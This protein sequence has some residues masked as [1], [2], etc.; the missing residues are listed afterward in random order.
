MLYIRADMNDIIATGHVMRCLAI[1]EA[2]K[3]Q[4]EDATFL[5]ADE[6]AVN[7]IKERG[8]QSIV[9]HT[10]WNDMEAELP[11]IETVIRE[12]NIKKL[13]IDSYQ[14]TPKY[15]E[16]LTAIVK[17]IYIDDLNAFVY[18]VNAL[19]CYANFWEK[20]HYKDNYH[21]TK[22][23]LGPKYTPLRKEFCNCEKKQI[24]S[25][26]ENIILLSGG[27]DNYDILNQI[28]KKIEKSRYQS[29]DVICGRY[30]PNY[31]FLCEKYS[32]NKNIHIY[33]AVSNIDYYMKKADFAV[34]AGGTTLYELCA[35]GIPTISY[36]IADNQLDNVKKFQEDGTID[37]IGDARTDN[38][39]EG[40]VS[41]L[42]KYHENVEIRMEKSE[43]MQE[44]VDGKGA[45]RIVEI[46]KKEI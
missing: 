23:F 6:Q 38:I 15:L 7:L 22:L 33:Q 13:F 19:I 11:I 18:P 5:L 1:A 14:V 2:A 46:F 16:K 43:K 29:I 8:F 35:L 4:G 34:A 30:Y 40:I 27:T 36:S 17:T 39:V 44:L 10:Q 24:K 37:Y 26:V 21:K 45:E 20:F 41:Y 12:R 32:G 28:L 3:V 9:L 42:E 25:Q 31:H